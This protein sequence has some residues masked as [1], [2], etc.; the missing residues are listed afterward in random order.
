MTAIPPIV[1][2]PPV[3][4]VAGSV[5]IS[6]GM[7]NP[8]A[9][10][11]GSFLMVW[12]RWNAQWV[13]ASSNPTGSDTAGTSG[14][15]LVLPFGWDGASTVRTRA[16]S[17]FKPQNAVAIVAEVAIWAPPAGKRFRLMGGTLASSVAGNIVLRDGLAGT[18]IAVIPTLA[19]APIAFARGNGQ[20]SAAANNALTAQGPAAATLSGEIYGTEE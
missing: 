1:V 18:I 4:G 12:D 8:T 17:I 13:R 10:P 19:G 20:L 5:P 6:D 11:V 9:P 7:P 14:T 15:L 3:E 16:A 2:A